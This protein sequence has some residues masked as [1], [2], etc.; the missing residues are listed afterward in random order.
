MPDTGNRRYLVTVLS[1]GME[2]N[3]KTYSRQDVALRIRQRLATGHWEFTY[4]GANQDLSAVPED[5]GIPAG[6][7]SPYT[8]TGAGTREVWRN[9]ADYYLDFQVRATRPDAPLSSQPKAPDEGPHPETSDPEAQPPN[10]TPPPKT[11]R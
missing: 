11:G 9:T 2:N 8:A 5:L 3:S 4:L 6:Y 7:V 1:D 10:D